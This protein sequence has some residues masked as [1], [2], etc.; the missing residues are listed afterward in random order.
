MKTMDSRAN[1]SIKQ[2]KLSSIY[3]EIRVKSVK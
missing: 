3:D 1:S 2:A